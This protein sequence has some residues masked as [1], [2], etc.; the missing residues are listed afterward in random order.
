MERRIVPKI[1]S[2][3]LSIFLISG[4]NSCQSNRR[5]TAREEAI[6]VKAVMVT[7]RDISREMRFTGSIEA[8]TEVKVFPKITARIE[9]IYVD[10]GDSV[11]KDDLIA[12]L[13]SDELKAQVAQA[14]AA[15]ETMRAKWAQIE[16]GV[17]PEEIAQARDLVTKAE[18]KFQEAQNHYER[19][20]GL[21]DRGV[22][23]KSNLEAAELAYR[24]AQADLSSAHKQLKILLEGATQ[25]ER[26]ALL[27]QLRQAEASL[28]VAKI[29]LSY[30]RITSPIDGIVSQRF[31]DPGHLAVPAQSLFTLVQMDFVKVIVYFPE[32]QVR[33]IVPGT[34]ATLQV[35]AYPNRVFQGRIDKVSPTLDPATRLFSAEI[36]VANRGYLLRPGMFTN[37]TLYV[38]PRKNALLVPKEAV[39]YVEEYPEDLDFGSREIRHHHYLFVAKDG[40]AHRRKVLLGYESGPMVEILEGLE[41]G[42]QV[43]TH[44]I[45]LLK[46]GDR[47]TLGNPE[48]G[49][50]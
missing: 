7:Q 19:M 29:R 16:V 12:L 43:I 48:E 30:A 9:A 22:I 21:F 47:V 41:K 27:A 26:Q 39:L 42:E 8:T 28:D 49:K 1:A 4:L 38:E 37:V 17:R 11:K 50:S 31:F 36:K 14:E 46:D 24:V 33:S 2:F 45:H 34:E 6:P 44:G 23:A 32:Q 35:A 15:L 40:R 3:V 25:E 5:E 18:A 13:E 10:V 20:K